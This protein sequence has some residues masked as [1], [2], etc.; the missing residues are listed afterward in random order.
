MK[1]SKVVRGL[2]L[3]VGV[4][5]GA[6]LAPGVALAA[7]DDLGAHG[8]ETNALFP[9]AGRAS[10]ALSTGVPFWV[11]SELS[12][13]IGDHAAVGLL[14]GATPQVSGF[15]LRPRGELVISEQWSVLGV[16]SA[17]YYPPSAGSRQWWLVRP[18]A[19]LERHASWGT[20]A[21]GGGAVAAA[22]QDALFGTHEHAAVV[23]PYPSNAPQHFDHGFWLTANALVTLRVSRS[24]HLFCDGALVLDTNFGVAGRDWVGG[25]PLIAFLGVETAL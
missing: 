17:L 10:V 24:T 5:L 1:E 12:I 6:C 21:L 22:T 4:A 9:G 15:G 11:M 20:V 18:S 8:A 25:P 7:S 23:S 2:C 14:A 19:L 3:A 13:G 16:A